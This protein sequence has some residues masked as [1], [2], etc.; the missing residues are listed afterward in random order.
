DRLDGT[1]SAACSPVRCVQPVW[2]G[3]RQGLD[4]LCRQYGLPL[5]FSQGVLDYLGAHSQKG[6]IRLGRCVLARYPAAAEDTGLLLD[7]LQDHVAALTAAMA[8]ADGVSPP[9]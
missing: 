9:G 8:E 7:A 1:G 2:R 4:S 5:D 6:L 3:F